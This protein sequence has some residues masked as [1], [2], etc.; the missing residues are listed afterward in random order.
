MVKKKPK[1]YAAVIKSRW[2]ATEYRYG[3]WSTAYEI[4]NPIS[5]VNNTTWVY[6]VGTR[7]F[8]RDVGSIVLVQYKPWPSESVGKWL[9]NWQ[10]VEE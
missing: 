3:R 6:E 1:T 4:D 7:T 2:D 10:I 8:K 5:P 9:S